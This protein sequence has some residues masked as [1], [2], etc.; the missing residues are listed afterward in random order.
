[1]HSIKSNTDIT[2]AILEFVPNSMV[3]TTV[4]N[5]SNGKLSVTSEYSTEITKE[6]TSPYD[7]FAQIVEGNAEIII[8]K[9]SHLLLTGRSIVIPAHAPNYMRANW[10]FKMILTSCQTALQ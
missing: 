2:V 3:I 1:M 6:K 7:S 5:K 4:F 8:N 9:E 10:R